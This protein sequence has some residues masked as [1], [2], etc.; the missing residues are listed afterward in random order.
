MVG[1][2]SLPESGGLAMKN[3]KRETV[4]FKAEVFDKLQFLFEEYKYNDHQLHCI[5][6]FKGRLN[7]DIFEKAVFMSIESVPILG[8][9]YVFDARDP[10]WE[11]IGKSEY[12][13]AISFEECSNL[14]QRIN[15]LLTSRTSVLEG[16]QVKF[17]VL[18]GPEN[19]VLS[20]AMNHMVC[21]AA[22]FKD[23]LYLLGSIY[24]NLIK[25]PAYITSTR[26]KGTRSLNQVFS[27]LN[28][29]N[30]TKMLFLSPNSKNSQYKLAT[31]YP[32]NEAF[33]PYTQIQKLPST[34]YQALKTYC[35]SKNVTLNNVMLAA[36]YRTL[37]RLFN[38][39][40]NIA[41]NIPCTIDLRRYLPNQKAQTICNLASWI[42]CDIIP[43]ENEKFD[44]TVKRVHIV[45]E[46]KKKS[47]PGLN[48]LARLSL[49]SQIFPYSKFKE[50]IKRN[51]KYPLFALTNIGMIDKNSLVFDQ[52]CVTDAFM[53][54]SIK[55]PPYFQMG[56][57]TFNNTITFSL[58]LSDCESDRELIKRY[59]DLFNRELKDNISG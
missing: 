7:R 42:M 54:G 24:S 2:A 32:T 58:N 13:K 15:E 44:E 55:Y 41:L 36:Y 3:N 11:S 59:F 39:K 46:S 33:Q 34:Q 56:L 47:F 49:V 21:D 40:S 9:R 31:E 25:N 57:S 30:K 5:I 17:T 52:L 6:T 19:D 27:R 38:I 10:Y 35:E 43:G 16:P 50:S 28:I 48:G 29:I 23:Y 51:L 14:D 20:V 4:R 8:C 18:T 12:A 53:T 1:H 37:Y 26:F 22:G 45:M